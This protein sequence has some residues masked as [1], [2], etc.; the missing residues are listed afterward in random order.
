M[1]DASVA[2]RNSNTTSSVEILKNIS[3][4]DSF[5]INIKNRVQQTNV[6]LKMSILVIANKLLD[7]RDSTGALAGRFNI[8]E[9]TNSFFGNEDPKIEEKIM[10]ELPGIFNLILKASDKLLVHPKSAD[11]MAEF[12]KLSSPYIA[13]ANEMCSLDPDAFIP[14]DLIYQYYRA[15]AKYCNFACR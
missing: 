3:G 7:L 12:E 4:E 5:N 9:M 11:I 13:F 14:C 10:S 2:G 8:L 1:W 15:W 6:K